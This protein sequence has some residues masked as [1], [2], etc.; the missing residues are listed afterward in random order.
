MKKLAR[1]QLYFGI[2][3]SSFFSHSSSGFSHFA[4]AL[5]FT[6]DPHHEEKQRLESARQELTSAL[7]RV[8]GAL[9]RPS[10]NNRTLSP[11]ALPANVG[12]GNQNTKR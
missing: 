8:H 5:G 12:N 1:P 6:S 10:D 9:N 2:G 7:E 11:A 3:A 4:L